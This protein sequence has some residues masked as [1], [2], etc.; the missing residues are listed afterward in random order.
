MN[1]FLEKLIKL[2]REPVR[3]ILLQTRILIQYGIMWKC[4]SNVD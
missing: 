3:I 4:M 1:K 2:D